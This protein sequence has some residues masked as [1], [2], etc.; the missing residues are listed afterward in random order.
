MTAMEFPGMSACDL[1][2][3][4]QRGILHGA[5]CIVPDRRAIG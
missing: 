3:L 5:A 1:G 4:S 2:L